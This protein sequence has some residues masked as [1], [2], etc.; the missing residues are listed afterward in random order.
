MVKCVHV[1]VKYCMHT[2]NFC[3]FITYID[4]NYARSLLAIGMYNSEQYRTYDIHS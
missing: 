1:V 2:P 3:G 4:L